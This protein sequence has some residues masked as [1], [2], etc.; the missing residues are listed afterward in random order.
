MAER[1][2]PKKLVSTQRPSHSYRATKQQHRQILRFK[3]ILEQEP[4]RAIAV[5][6]ELEAELPPEI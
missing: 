3:R 6:D 5:L 4:E 1:G 2:R